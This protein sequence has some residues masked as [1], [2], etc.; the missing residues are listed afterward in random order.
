MDSRASSAEPRPTVWTTDSPAVAET[1]PLAPAP[2]LLDEVLAATS[3]KTA[4]PATP[5]RLDQFLHEK[6][7]IDALHLW[8]GSLEELRG[9]DARRKLSQRLARDVATLDRCLSDQTNAVLHHPKFQKLEASWRGLQYLVEQVPAGENIK[10]RVLSVSWA[11]LAR[12]AERALEFDQSQLFR[13]VYSEEFGTPGGEP[14]SLLLG[15]YEVRHRLSADHPIDDLSLLDSISHVAA[16]AFAPFIAGA[17]PSLLDLTSFTELEKPLDLARTFEQIEYLK[18]KSLRN[19]E[20]ARFVGLV[21]PRVLMRLPYDDQTSRIDGFNFREEVHAADRQGYLWGSPVYAF[22]AVVVRAFGDSGWPAAIRGV[23]RGETTGGLVTGLT[24]HDFNTDKPGI[25]PKCLTDGIVTDAQEKELSDLGLIPLCHLQ[26][27]GML[28]FYS[29][30]SIQQPR[31]YD[32]TA[33]TVNARISSMLQYMLCISRFAH[34]LKVISR[35]KVGAFAGA[36]ECEDHLRR[37]L[38]NYVN[39]SENASAQL[40]ARHPLREAKVQIREIPDRP[41]SYRCVAHLRPHFQLD[42]MVTSV[43][44]VTELTPGRRGA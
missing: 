6:S 29:N 2:S 12:D 40:K 5:G 37:W 17:H 7:L 1:L 16:G 39:S 35:D 44:L 33:A 34:Y 43:R 30:Q 31:Q 9:P 42:Q 23:V 24:T 26:D 13:K 22:G 3:S 41:G 28:A 36:T 4:R 18:W 38:S 20:D 8:L 32:E 21:L 25:A 19:H 15:D 10:V 27:A 14:F 11:E